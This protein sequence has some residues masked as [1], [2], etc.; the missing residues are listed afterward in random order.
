MVKKSSYDDLETDYFDEEAGGSFLSLM[1]LGVAFVAVAVFI[2]LAWYAYQDDGNE[3]GQVETIYAQEGDVR[4]E[5]EGDTG[6]Q[7]PEAERQVYNLGSGEVEDDTK[8][9]QILPQPERPQPRE[10]AAEATAEAA[11]A[12]AEGWINKPEENA[13]IALTDAE[14]RKM[15]E[16]AKAVKETTEAVKEV[17][18]EVT[19]ATPEV[20][21]K[22]EEV[23]V[24]QPK[25]A[26]PVVKAEVVETTEVVTPQ[27]SN[28]PAVLTRDRLQLGAFGSHAEA[29]KNWTKIQ[30]ANSS[31]LGSKKAFIEEAEVNGKMFYRVQAYP[32]DSKAA[33]DALCVMLK[34]RNQA[35]FAVKK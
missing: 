16:T 32:F 31:L 5:P 13:E 11:N 12:G 21:V 34:S 8:V 19:P 22:S 24:E 29:V 18:K 35:C 7:Y 9:E 28:A 6:W 14:R 20:V 4:S 33:A 25:A 1:S 2:A 23:I 15:E 17:A 26:A 10:A 3:D 30:S 27:P